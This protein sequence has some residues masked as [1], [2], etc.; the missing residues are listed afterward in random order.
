MR[1][2]ASG[3]LMHISSLPGSYGIGDFGKEAYNFVDFLVKAKQS[4]WQILPLG[5]TGYGDSPYSSFSAFAGNPYF[6]DLDELIDNGFI[7]KEKVMNTDLGQNSNDIDY[8]KLYEY[9]MELLREAYIN[10]KPYLKGELDKFYNEQEKWLRDFALFMTIKESFD[11]VSWLDWPKEYKYYNSDIVKRFELENKERMFFWVFTQ[12]YFTKQWKKLKLYANRNG[13]KII[14]DLPIYVAADSVDAWSNPSAFNLDKNLYPITIAGCPPD[15][16]TETGQLWGNPIYNWNYLESTEYR[17][18]IERIRYSFKLFD[19]LRIDHFR[20][21]DAYWEVKYG[22]KTAQNGRWIKGPGIKLFNRIKEELGDLD[23][24]AEDL[25]YPT[26]SLELFLKE[27][28]FPNMKVLEFAF[29]T[30]GN[31]CYLPHNYGKNCVVYIGTHDNH[32][33]MSWLKNAPKHECEYAVKYLR[34]NEEEG[35]HWGF[36]KGA[37]SSTAYLAIAQMQDF[38]GTGEET[39]MNEPSTLGKNW[40]WRVS[41]VDLT[42]ELA[43]KIAGITITYGRQAIGL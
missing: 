15:G 7:S 37:W 8:G 12:Y 4:Y 43:E 18:W 42:D 38:L 6:I 16:F 30:D 1:K 34:L 28:G 25:G 19:T 26:K 31:N 10:S 36:I 40:R 13:I 39:R 32:P 22:D 11:S 27:V 14:G 33:A 41:K 24:I 20:G 2:R 21:F 29:D 23:I 17:W 35:F 3:I 9:K 5:I